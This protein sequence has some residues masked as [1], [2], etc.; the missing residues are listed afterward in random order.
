MANDEK[1][2]RP[3]GSKSSAG[4]SASIENPLGFDHNDAPDWVNG[5]AAGDEPPPP[6]ASAADLE[7]GEA[8]IEPPPPPEWTPDRAAAV[9]RG[10]GFVLGNIDPLSTANP[11]DGYELW[12]WTEADALEAGAPLARI[13]NRYSPSRRLAAVSDEA[14]LAF[15]IGPYLRR[16]LVAR[17]QLSAERKEAEEPGPYEGA[18]LAVPPTPG[19]PDLFGGGGAEPGS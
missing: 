19:D 6:P 15:A 12:R 16:N 10:L 1:P 17:A 5:G 13:L 3:G 11:D 9:L 7:A 14:E 8:E 4:P 18:D 2:S